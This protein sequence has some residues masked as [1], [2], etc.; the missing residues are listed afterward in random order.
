MTHTKRTS[1]KLSLVKRRICSKQA[2]IALS[3]IDCVT[4]AGE[5]LLTDFDFELKVTRIQFEELIQDLSEMIVPLI[6]G[7]FTKAEMQKTEINEIIVVGGSTR[8][9]K[10]QRTIQNMF[11]GM[12]LNQSIQADSGIAQ[13][14]ATQAAKLIG[15]NH[16]NK[17]EEIPKMRRDIFP[18]GYRSRQ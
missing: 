7:T 10:I 5:N 11:G 4:I 6:E 14:A 8:I 12:E 9:S 13:G 18:A 15:L 2:K 16:D 3:K 1:K 17:M